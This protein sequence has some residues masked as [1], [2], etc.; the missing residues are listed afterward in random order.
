MDITKPQSDA[1][2]SW[3]ALRRVLAAP[4]IGV[5][6]PL[7][8]FVALFYSRN[9]VMLSQENITVI[10]KT[11]SY[12]GI[13]AVGQGLLMIAG[14][15]D[16]SV[17]AVAGLSAVMSAWLM[18]SEKWSVPAAVLASVLAGCIAGLING[19]VTVKIGLPA[20]IATLGMLFVARGLNFVISKGQFIP[21]LPQEFTDFGTATPLGISPSFI[22]WIVLVIIGDFMLRQTIFGSMIAATGGNKQAARV[23]GINTDRVKI[24]CFILTGALAA[25]SGVLVTGSLRTGNYDTGT[26]WEL[27]AIA[28]VVIGGVSLFGGVGTVFGTFLGALL[29]QVVQSGLVISSVNINWQ[30]IVVGV[31]LAIAASL[32][33]LRRRTAFKS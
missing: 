27:T 12:V 5:L 7:V 13:V 28:S 23:A 25:I 2:I 10:L 17:G 21:R 29:M 33:M 30:N 19:L 31:I 1:G 9:N 15:I 3:G 26:G 11:I 6:I 14:E 22:L 32:D 4:E 20:F 8:V 18:V 16:L 24:G